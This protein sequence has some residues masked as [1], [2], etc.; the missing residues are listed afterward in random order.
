[1]RTHGA[2]ICIVGLL[3][4]A[5]GGCHRVY[6][7]QDEPIVGGE[8]Q[9]SA[10]DVGKAIKKACISR[11]WLIQKDEPGLLEASFEKGRAQ[12]IVEIQYGED[13]YSIEPVERRHVSV[14]KMNQWVRNLQKLIR[15]Q[16]GT[17]FFREEKD[18]DS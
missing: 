9:M 10:E 13:S 4:L 16:L 15:K 12:V 11:N 14:K 6:R 8:T 17:R 2:W 5:M 7:V 18:E 3:A 1:M